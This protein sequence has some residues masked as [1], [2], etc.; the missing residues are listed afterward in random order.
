MEL[1]ESINKIKSFICLKKTNDKP[2]DSSKS[3]ESQP[4]NK[5]SKTEEKSNEKTTKDSSDKNVKTKTE[6]KT[7]DK[8]SEAKTDLNKRIFG[9]WEA[10]WKG[11]DGT[12]VG[13]KEEFWELVKENYEIFADGATRNQKNNFAEKDGI[14]DSVKGVVAFQAVIGVVGGIFYKLEYIDFSIFLT[15]FLSAAALLSIV[16]YAKEKHI[17]VHKY[18]ETW[19]RHRNSLSKIQMEMV[20][21]SQKLAPY[22]VQDGD[23]RDMTFKIRFMEIMNEN[24]EKFVDNMENKEISLSDLPDKLNLKAIKDA[25][26]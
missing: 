1:K 3:E 18:Q 19:V 10:A 26:T 13:C 9:S 22:D 21:Y 2:D 11:N 4:E 8:T 16:L 12:C 20:K 25:I 15:F 5:E 17:G 24:N 6:E 23:E 7:A 14:L